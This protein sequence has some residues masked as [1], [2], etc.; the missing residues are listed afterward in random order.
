MLYI[1]KARGPSSG[2][3]KIIP[4][5]GASS[6]RNINPRACCWGVVA[7]S[8]SMTAPSGKRTGIVNAPEQEDD[9]VPVEQ[10]VAS[11]TAAAVES[12]TTREHK[13]RLNRDKAGILR[14][15]STLGRRD[16]HVVIGVPTGNGAAVFEDVESLLVE[17]AW[18]RDVAS[19]SPD[20]LIAADRRGQDVT[21]DIGKE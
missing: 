15:E 11:K 19:P 9:R 7:G 17:I 18:D 16:H 4:R 6:L 8:A 5:S 14:T 10:P 2:N 20:L 1:Q 3:M 12:A 21:V 13:C